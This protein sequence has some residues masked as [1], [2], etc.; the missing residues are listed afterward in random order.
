MCISKYINTTTHNTEA[1]FSAWGTAVSP[2]LNPHRGLL[3]CVC[4][5]SESSQTG[6]LSVCLSPSRRSPRHGDWSRHRD[7]LNSTWTELAV[8]QK[9]TFGSGLALCPSHGCALSYKP[10]VQAAWMVGLGERGKIGYMYLLGSRIQPPLWFR[11]T[12]FVRDKQQCE[13]C[14]ESHTF[15]TIIFIRVWNRATY[16]CDQRGASKI[17]CTVEKN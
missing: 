8:H 13:I 6:C 17:R 12:K 10:V 11:T 3:S 5:L 15:M 4:S 2:P 1:I 9:L 7:R 16:S 14:K